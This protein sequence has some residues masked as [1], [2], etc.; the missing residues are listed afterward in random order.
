[1]I[2]TPPSLGLRVRRR[3]AP[4]NGALITVETS[5]HPAIGGT[6]ILYSF[7]HFSTSRRLVSVVSR[8]VCKMF[9]PSTMS[10]HASKTLPVSGPDIVFA[11]RYFG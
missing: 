7:N 11:R 10:N 2:T 8:M 4:K 9:T 1:V 5:C 6:A 3:L